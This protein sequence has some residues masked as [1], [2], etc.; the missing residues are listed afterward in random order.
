VISELLAERLGADAG[1]AVPYLA[2]PARGRCPRAPAGP[3][4]R[5]AA[6]LDELARGPALARELAILWA[7][8][9]SACG[10]EPV[11]A[12]LGIELAPGDRVRRDPRTEIVRMRR[13]GESI[14]AVNGHAFALRGTGERALRRI[15]ASLERG[16]GRVDALCR[17]DAGVHAVLEMLAELRALAVTAVEA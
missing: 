14:W 4:L 3:L 9:V 17:G 11:P 6:V 15:V 16:G 10:L 1:G 12:P 13:H 8:R 2:Y 5:A 7:K